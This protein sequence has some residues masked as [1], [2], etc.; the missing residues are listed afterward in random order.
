[1]DKLKLE[2]AKIGDLLIQ[3]GLIDE[4]Q[5]QWALSQ[6]A[7]QAVYKP[8]GEILIKGGFVSRKVLKGVLLRHRK[9]IQLGELLIKMGILTRQQ[10][11]QALEVQGFAGKKLG[12]VLVERR[13][14]T[15]A[16]LSDAV[17]VQL[18]ITGVD[19]G[20]DLA[21]KEL[22]GKV[23]ATFLRRRRVIPLKY[24]E[25]HRTLTVLMEDP[26]DTETIADLEKMF[27]AEILPVMLREGSVDQLLDGILDIW[28]LSQ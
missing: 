12:Q 17:C 6:Q 19:T 28:S 5:L 22:L 18:G 7:G 8:L 3:E 15:R 9:Q 16:Q 26:T 1:M 2:K 27:R 24:D 11:V 20:S 14:V 13:F 25:T 23:N 21:D 4:S 10:L